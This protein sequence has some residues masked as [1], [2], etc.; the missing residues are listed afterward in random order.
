[1]RRAD[2]VRRLLTGYV[3][4]TAGRR[5]AVRGAVMDERTLPG[6][7]G[8]GRSVCGAVAGRVSEW[9]GSRGCGAGE[10]AVYGGEAVVRRGFGAPAE[11]VPARGR[12]CEWGPVRGGDVVRL[13]VSVGVL[14]VVSVGSLGEPGRSPGEGGGVVDVS[15]GGCGRGWGGGLPGLRAFEVR[16]T[17][18]G[19]ADVHLVDP[20]TGAVYAEAEGL[21]PGAAR[22][23]RA[24][25]GRGAYAFVC[26]FDDADAVT[27]P[28]VRVTGGPPPGPAAVPV[29]R[30]DLVPAV[31]DQQR[32]LGARLDGLVAATDSLRAAV[33]DG[34]RDGAR[35]AWLDA[36]L[37]YARLGAAY[38]A[39]GAVGRAVDGTDAGLPGGVRDA[40]FTGFHRIEYGLWHGERGPGPRRAARRLAADVRALRAGW[41]GVRLD[42]LDLVRRAHEILEDTLQ[43]ELTGR[44]DYGS[45]SGLATARAH[46]DAAR[47][48]LDSL[49]P[50]L[51]SRMPRPAL[52]S[53]DARLDRTRRDLEEHLRH[54]EWT[55]L[56]RLS[57][58]QRALLDAD[59][60]DAAERLARVAALC[61][62]RRA[63]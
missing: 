58:A 25:L 44:T 5:R 11:A 27:G 8:A 52:A 54:G 23:V 34:D 15:P 16:N 53:L 62:P 41:D 57:R 2:T 45:G 63:A 50:V 1:M 35:A 43:D 51:R 61:E 24:R 36:H 48:A 9:G 46:L 14:F 30:Q 21:G 26:L 38:G 59:F 12:C 39:F 56:S 17:S 19:A 13:V 28:T 4:G 18:V 49:R 37:R 60:G 3:A 55:P 47:A 10:G 6:R 20:G 40:D 31:L 22:T 32:R 33:E 29:T 42:P 7:A